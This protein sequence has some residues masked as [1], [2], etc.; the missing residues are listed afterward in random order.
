MNTSHDYVNTLS[1][2]PYVTNAT[3]S[4]FTT[5]NVLQQLSHADIEWSVIKQ[6]FCRYN[7]LY[8]KIYEA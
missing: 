1:F 5:I 8:F 4:I 7:Q 3:L 2:C 6:T